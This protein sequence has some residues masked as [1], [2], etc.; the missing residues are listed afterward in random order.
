MNKTMII[1]GWKTSPV[2]TTH[3]SNLLWLAKVAS[4]DDSKPNIYQTIHVEQGICYCTDGHRMHV[5]NQDGEYLPA[6][7]F[8]ADGNYLIRSATRKN[9]I[10]V[11]KDTDVPYPDVNQLLN[12]T[13]DRTLTGM[14][15]SDFSLFTF[16]IFSKLKTLISIDY[17]H[18]A[19]M[20]DERVS[21]ERPAGGNALLFG[22][23]SRIA[24]VMP[25]RQ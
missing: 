25:L 7:F 23:E 14:L 16:D 22:N 4:K 12:Y 11:E 1:E 3:L 8:V 21:F 6:D 19:Y 5:Y 2:T 15:Y 20:P 17:L 9:I 18:D 10:L 13:P 24:M